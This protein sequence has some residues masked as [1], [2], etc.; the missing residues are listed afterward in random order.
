MLQVGQVFMKTL[1]GSNWN[2]P[3]TFLIIEKVSKAGQSIQCQTYRIDDNGILVPCEKLKYRK[4]ERIRKDFF[5]SKN[6]R[7]VNYT[8]T[9]EAK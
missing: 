3:N 6:Y 8:Y 5:V 4:G 2:N 7:E 9:V 1:N